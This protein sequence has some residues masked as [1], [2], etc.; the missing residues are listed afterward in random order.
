[1]DKGGHPSRLIGA[2]ENACVTGR[3]AAGPVGVGAC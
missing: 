1:V 2:I 3:N